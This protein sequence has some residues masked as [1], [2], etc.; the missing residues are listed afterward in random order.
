MRLSV[1]DRYDKAC[2]NTGESGLVIA[3]ILLAIDDLAESIRQVKLRGCFAR[4]G[5]SCIMLERMIEVSRWFRR[6]DS[7]EGSFINYCSMIG[8]D[9]SRLL[10]RISAMLGEA[11]NLEI[12]SVRERRRIGKIIGK[13]TSETNDNDAMIEF[14]E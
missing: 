3:I 2:A 12:E 5:N 14:F 8:I 10:R 13:I 1:I 6:T 9:H 7:R 4:D 11:R